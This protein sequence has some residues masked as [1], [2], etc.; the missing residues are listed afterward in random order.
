MDRLDSRFPFTM[1]RL[2]DLPSAE[3]GKRARYYDADQPG[4]LLQVT[5]R[6]AKSFY[7]MRRTSARTDWIRLGAFPA[8]SV[9]SAQKAAR[10]V[11]SE[12]DA[13]K[14]PAEAKR[15]LRGEPTFGEVF[16]HYVAG[17][18]AKGRK[19]T[20]DVRATYELHL[21]PL[22]DAPPKPR[23]RK[24]EKPAYGVDWSRR[25]ASAITTD[26]LAKLHAKIGAAGR[27]TTANRV[28]EIV[29]AMYN[30]ASQGT[31]KL[32]DCPN[33]AKGIAPF[34]ET[35]RDRHLSTDEAKRLMRALDS[36]SEQWRDFFQLLLMTGQRRGNVRAMRWRDVDL[37]AET[38][39]LSGAVTKQGKPVS[40]PLT[41]QAV[42]I[43]ARRKKAL[44]DVEYVFPGEG[45]QGHVVNVKGA[46]ARVRERAGL[47]DF[48]PH[49][50]RHTAASWLAQRGA[51]LP[52]I[53]A[54][55]GHRDV[56]STMR[57]AH[58]IVDPVRDAMQ[59]AMDDRLPAPATSKPRAKARVFAFKPRAAKAR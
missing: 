45:E 51:S 36:E 6:G 37:H 12:F 50:L 15:K 46:W 30:V 41:A 9:D 11:A 32:I 26:E 35:L 54:A 16:E 34:G 24:R 49:D 31:P 42:A 58:M 52:I 19:R 18:V 3:P 21:G 28:V 59:T 2:R 38:W 53:G 48:R 20:D 17:L 56:A 27:K 13:G 4:L 33:P 44:G 25:K 43:L 57:Y 14:N 39:S 29:S 7:F 40:V 55:L 8:M 47:D 1:A 22:P 10:K 5:D 23:G